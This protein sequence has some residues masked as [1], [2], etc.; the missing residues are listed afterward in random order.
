MDAIDGLLI[1]TL[2]AVLLSGGAVA[3]SSGA[4]AASSGAP[5]APESA[6]CVRNEGLPMSW[7]TSCRGE[8]AAHRF[9][10]TFVGVKRRLLG[11]DPSGC[12]ISAPSCIDL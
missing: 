3:A 5:G 2:A 8:T 6:C 12:H 9:T 4:V 1:A 11:P 7:S 10:D